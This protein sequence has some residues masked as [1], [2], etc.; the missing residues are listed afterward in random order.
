M[1]V[2]M[3]TWGTSAQRSPRSQLVLLSG[4]D[5]ER[6]KAHRRARPA[7]NAPRRRRL[8]RR[9][10]HGGSRSDVNGPR[11][12]GSPLAEAISCLSASFP[13]AF[14]R[15]NTPRSV[16]LPRQRAL[17]SWLL[18]AGWSSP[19]GRS[20]STTGTRRRMEVRY[21]GGLSGLEYDLDA[22]VLLIAKRLVELRPSSSV[23]RW[24]M[25]KEGSIRPSSMRR[26]RCGR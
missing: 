9:T 1:A 23:P 8:P 19:E 11:M 20:C 13:F 5:V 24:V 2:A 26:S 10:L 4:C 12:G 18:S 6:P 15:P 16:L 22:A 21:D 14:F 17:R 3:L 25:T 7:R